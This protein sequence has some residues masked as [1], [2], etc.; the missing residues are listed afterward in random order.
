M[1]HKIGEIRQIK[2]EWYQCINP[3][4]YGCSYC[5]LENKCVDDIKGK[6]AACHARYRS[7]G[8]SV[9]F[10]KLEKVGEPYFNGQYGEVLQE[11]KYYIPPITPD[12]RTHIIKLRIVGIEIKQNKED[13]EDNKLNLKPFNLQ[14]AK[15]GKPVCTRDGRKARIVCF[16]REYLYEGQNYSIVALIKSPYSETIYSYTKDGLYNSNAIHDND[17]MM[18]CEKKEG[19][20]NLYHNSNDRYAGYLGN[21]VIYKDEEFARKIGKDCPNYIKTIKVEWYE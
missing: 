16:D 11:Y 3:E 10:K 1:E 8:K 4:I 6:V 17:L 15:A 14:K 21:N 18:R 2:G 5:D 7:D 20:V 12:L 9:I 13:M 19:Y